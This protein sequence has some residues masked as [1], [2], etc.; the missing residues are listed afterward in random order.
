[1]I[2]L[3]AAAARALACLDLTDLS[4]DCDLARVEALCGRAV[5]PHGAVAAICIWP[6]FVAAARPL[7]APDVRIAT[8]VNFP[9]GEDAPEDYVALTER[10]IADG[11]DEID[12]VIPYRQL[13]EGRPQAVPAAVE[14]VVRAAGGAPVKAILETGVLQDADAIRQAAELAIEG[15]ARFLKTSTGKAPVN[16]TLGAAQIMLEVIA[17]RDPGV[18]FKAAGGVRTAAE[19]A[20]YLELADR[21]MGAGWAD[22]THF[23]IGASGLLD[24]LLAVLDGRDAPASAQGY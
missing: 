8:V 4:D 20:A 16:A 2:D 15:G 23:R 19:A 10:A 13:L 3:R 24:A 21:L 18:G 6:R 22:P 17:A 14:R 12:M 11:A 1:M 5:T 9:G 7:L